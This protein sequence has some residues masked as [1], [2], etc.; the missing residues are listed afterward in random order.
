M[1]IRPTFSTRLTASPASPMI[2]KVFSK[3]NSGFYIV[4]FSVSMS[5]FFIIITGKYPIL[6]KISSI[7]IGSE[8]GTM[9]KIGWYM[10]QCI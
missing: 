6:F 1:K 5:D 8:I 7:N 10:N 2:E 4:K 9:M 3:L